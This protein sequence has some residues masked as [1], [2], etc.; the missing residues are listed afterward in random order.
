MNKVL[1][2]LML[3]LFAA[4]C[5]ATNRVVVV[6]SF[7]GYK[8][9]S[10]YHYRQGDRAPDERIFREERLARPFRHF[11]NATLIYGSATKRL[12]QVNISFRV[13]TDWT[14]EMYRTELNTVKRILEA[15]YGALLTSGKVMMSDEYNYN[16]VSSNNDLFDGGRDKTYIGAGLSYFRADVQGKEFRICICRNDLRKENSQLYERK[17]RGAVK[18]AVEKDMVGGGAEVL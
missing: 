10:L 8:L 7:C 3:G 15:K 4:K 1:L 9:G 16:Y 11:T 13:P 14:L 2:I 5:P 17:K 18:K 12:F 6:D